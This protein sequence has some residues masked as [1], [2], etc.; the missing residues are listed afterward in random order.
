MAAA[1]LLL[2]QSLCEGWMSFICLQQ[3]QHLVPSVQCTDKSLPLYISLLVLLH[4]QDLFAH[5]DDQ[6]TARCSALSW[7]PELLWHQTWRQDPSTDA[8]LQSSSDMHHPEKQV[9]PS[10]SQQ[11]PLKPQETFISFLR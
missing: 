9:S 2:D 3:F 5:H 1:G 11:K 4:C 7:A 10:H 8:L 6:V